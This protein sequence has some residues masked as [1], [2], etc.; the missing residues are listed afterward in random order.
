MSRLQQEQITTEIRHIPSY[1]LMEM[2]PFTAFPP[3]P[4]RVTHTRQ[5]SKA[6]RGKTAP[7]QH[8]PDEWESL[9][10]SSWFLTRTWIEP[11]WAM[12]W[13]FISSFHRPLSVRSFNKCGFTTCKRQRPE[14]ESTAY[15]AKLLQHPAATTHLPI[16][17]SSPLFAGAGICV[18]RLSLLEVTVDFNC[19]N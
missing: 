15:S 12:I 16:L 10:R 18:N 1:F 7:S 4:G 11:L 17:P 5:T 13:F 6:L 2:L 8:C 14:N 9:H 3:Q 19:S